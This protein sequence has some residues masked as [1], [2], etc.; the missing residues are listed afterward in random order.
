MVYRTLILRTATVVKWEEEEEKD[1]IE[2]KKHLRWFTVHIIID[3]M[4][5]RHSSFS[6][7]H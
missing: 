7:W 2:K 6:L 4:V 3:N 5:T 1:W